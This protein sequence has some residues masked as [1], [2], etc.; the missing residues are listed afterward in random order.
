M[1]QITKSKVVYKGIF[2]KIRHDTIEI[3]GKSYIKEVVESNSGVFISVINRKN[4]ILLIKQ[5]RHNL[6]HIYEVPSGAMKKNE[7]PLESAKRELLEE[8]GITA[9]NWR[10]IS[11]HQNGVHNEGLNYFFI[12]QN[13]NKKRKKLD[14]DEDI[15]NCDFFDFQEVNQLMKNKLIP[16]LRSRAC[17]WKTQLDL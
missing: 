7:A 12:A 10:L 3:N 1:T 9:K 5:H 14:E 4:Q 17:I 16:D 6:G 8:T 2:V 11:T 13:I 15:G